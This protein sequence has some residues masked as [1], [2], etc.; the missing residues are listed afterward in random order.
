VPLVPL[1]PILGVAVCLGMMVFLPLDT[2][3]RLLVWMIIGINVYL[4]YGMKNSLLSD[5]LQATLAKSTKTVSNEGFGLAILLIIV[6]LNHHNITDGKDTGLY[7]FSLVFAV[8]HI[9]LYLYRASTSNRVQA[10]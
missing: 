2:W 1:I 5:N 9:I 4:F 10:K 8:A 6:A 7:Y 3:V